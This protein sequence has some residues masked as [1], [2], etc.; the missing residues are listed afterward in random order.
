M[1]AAE[2]YAALIDAVSAQHLRVHGEPASQDP[3]AG[4]LARLFRFDPHR[5]LDANLEIVASYVQPQDVVIDAGGGAGRAGLPLALRCGEVINVDPS[6][7]MGEQFEASAAEAGIK[8]ARR[9]RSSWLDA[10]VIEGD[11]VHCGDVA[12]FVRDIARFVRKL[13]A[14]ARR[15]VII[16]VWSVPPPY[17]N[18]GLYRLVYG[19]EQAVVPGHTH[20]LAVL[21]E[22]GILPDV[23]VMPLPRWW[24]T[25]LPR[26]RE[27]ALAFALE[28]SWLKEEDHALA[29]ERLIEQFDHLF[30]ECSEGFRPL[31]RGEERELL[32]TWETGRG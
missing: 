20:L 16:T 29:R 25:G 22:L 5:E 11:I 7:S 17:A 8:N 6:A 10:D 3:W 30:A 18:R 28:G 1:N 32:I 26:T 12:Y 21:W 19:E 24:D 23:R 27:D 9:V 14:A 2:T 13:E 31:W 15:R 4:R